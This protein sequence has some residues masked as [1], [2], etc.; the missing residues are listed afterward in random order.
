VSD[1]VTPAVLYCDFA[2]L[3]IQV[4]GLAFC[5]V[6]GYRHAPINP[7]VKPYLFQTEFTLKGWL[8]ESISGVF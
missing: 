6:V 2:E 5:D 7:D 3:T 1:G 4:N 8:F